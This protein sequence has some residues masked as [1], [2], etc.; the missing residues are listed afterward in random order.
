[1]KDE[2]EMK[3]LHKLS[4]KHVAAV[5]RSEKIGCYFCTR[6]FE[7]SEIE[8]WV[9]KGATAI[10]PNCGIDSILPDATA[11]IDT[12]TLSKMMAFWFGRVAGKIRA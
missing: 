1:M 11:P 4:S 3:R 12:D 6:T 9:D 10:C 8:E 2:R 7:A 5:K